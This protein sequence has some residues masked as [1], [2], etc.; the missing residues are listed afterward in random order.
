MPANLVILENAPDIYMCPFFAFKATYVHVAICFSTH[1]REGSMRCCICCLRR[2]TTFQRELAPLVPI[3]F[4]VVGQIVAE[5]CFLT[6]D[7]IF[8]DDPPPNSG[9]GPVASCWIEPR[10][11]DIS[12]TYWRSLE[13]TINT[14]NEYIHGNINTSCLITTGQDGS[15][16]LQVIWLA[17]HGHV[18]YHPTIQFS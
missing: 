18:R 8:P 7:G 15:M 12:H 9:L 16:Q 5:N 14:I 13:P 11:N 6:L 3:L 10:P 17:P 1:E 4:E 2:N